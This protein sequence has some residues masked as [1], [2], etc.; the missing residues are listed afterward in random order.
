MS[1]RQTTA[2]YLRLFSL[3]LL[4]FG[5]GQQCLAARPLL[6]FLI[7]GFRYDY[8]DDLHALPGFRELVGNGVKVD[9][10]TPDFPSLSYP[11]YY[12]IM[13]GNLTICLSVCLSFL[14]AY[15]RKKPAFERNDL[16]RKT[17][18]HIERCSQTQAFMNKAFVFEQ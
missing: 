18:E 14:S 9:Y 4:L 3:L 16:H 15:V 12:S 8:M 6:V 17:E 5:A 7:D 13:T 2:C 10:M 1:P 11:N